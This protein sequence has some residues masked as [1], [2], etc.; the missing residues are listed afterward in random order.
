M[1]GKAAVLV[2]FSIIFV[3]YWSHKDQLDNQESFEKAVFV[4]DDSEVFEKRKVDLNSEI[5]KYKRDL[6][7]LLKQYVQGLRNVQHFV[8]FIRFKFFQI[9]ILVKN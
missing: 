1:L 5:K 6:D 3:Y 4:E 7:S 2:A 9:K 8:F